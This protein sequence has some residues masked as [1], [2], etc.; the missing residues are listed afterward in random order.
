MMH[1]L[2]K[3]LVLF[4]WISLGIA[5]FVLIFKPFPLDHIAFDERKL[6]IF[7][8]G[9]IVFFCMILVRIISPCLAEIF[10][11]DKNRIASPSYLNSVVVWLTTSVIII[12]YLKTAGSVSLTLYTVIKSSLICLAPPLILSIHQK[13]TALKQSDKFLL[14]E[15]GNLRKIIEEYEKRDLNKSIDFSSGNKSE[16]ISLLISQIL[17]INSANNYS[18]IHYME[19]NQVKKILI[20]TTLRNIEIQL[21]PYFNFIRCHRTHIVNIYKIE[22]FINKSYSHG[23]IIEGYPDQIPVSRQYLLK[24]KEVL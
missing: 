16:R 17:F 14:S 6:F 13:M 7:G 3:E 24:I 4:L 9:F 5:L 1:M 23:L 11:E 15:V 20:R 12:I 21:R 18:E 22:K 10:T 19:E 8:L 2:T